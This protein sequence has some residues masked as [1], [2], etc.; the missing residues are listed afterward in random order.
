MSLAKYREYALRCFATSAPLFEIPPAETQQASSLRLRWFRDPTRD[1]CH[2][3][4]RGEPGGLGDEPVLRSAD[5]QRASF[6]HGAVAIERHLFRIHCTE[7][8]ED[9]CL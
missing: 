8:L 1:R 3:P 6:H 2:Q 7:F 5:R 9:A 4:A